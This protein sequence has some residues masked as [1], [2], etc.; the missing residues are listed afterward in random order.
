MVQ[1]E[2]TIR[3]PYHG[4]LTVTMRGI[5]KFFSMF[6]MLYGVPVL[7]GI[8]MQPDCSTHGEQKLNI[9]F[10]FQPIEFTLL[11]LWDRIREVDSCAVPLKAIHGAHVP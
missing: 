8:C 5:C 10:G 6:W 9:N 1:C 4:K 11:E 7:F 3:K 2:E